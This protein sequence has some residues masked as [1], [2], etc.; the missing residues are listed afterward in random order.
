MAVPEVDREPLEAGR[1]VLARW[2]PWLLLALVAAVWWPAL[3]GQQVYDDDLNFQRN[4]VLREGGIA[5]NC[6]RGFFREQLGYWRPAST[7]LM[8]CGYRAAGLFGVHL[9]ALL[10]HAFAVLAAHRLARRVFGDARAAVAVALLFALHPVQ[11]ESVA[12]ASALPSLLAALCALRAVDAA[13]RWRD[14]QGCGWPW[15]PAWWVALAL[16]ASEIGTI[17]VLLVPAVVTCVPTPRKQLA[18]LGLALGAPVAVWLALRALLLPNALTVHGGIGDA[19]S[20]VAGAAEMMLRSLALLFA[21][22]PLTPLRTLNADPWLGLGLAAGV[23]ALAAFV[24]TTWKRWPERWR[25]AFVFLVVPTLLPAAMHRALGEHP[26]ADRYLYL[27][28]F[29]AALA[30][31]AI[32]RRNVW[33]LVAPIAACAVATVVQVAVWRDQA[34]FVAHCAKHEP[35]D[36]EVQ[37]MSGSVHFAAAQAGEAPRLEMARR[38]YCAALASCSAPGRRC[39]DDLARKARLGLAWCDFLE[40]QQR[41]E[42]HVA[43][44]VQRFGAELA[45]AGTAASAWVGIGVSYSVAQQFDGAY[46]AFHRA[47]ELDPLSPEAWFDLGYLQWEN[48]ELQQARASLQR[49]LHCDPQLAAAADLLARLR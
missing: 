22:W 1:C 18:R 36:P 39:R 46:D 8:A 29:G 21:P 49:A 9:L 11:V 31:V 47:I 6:T 41:G 20:F 32:A 14:A 25:V 15:R 45:N 13:L 10:L 24:L 35:T 7:L 26:L 27:P 40:Q 44:L 4:V 5:D 19:V 23:V 33:L 17:A 2:A 16:F 12:W 3:A 37:V 43:S 34:T 38:A 30:W 48:G 28:A 42:F